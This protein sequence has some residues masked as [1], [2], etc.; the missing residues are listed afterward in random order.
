MKNEWRWKFWEIVATGWHC[1]EYD[2]IIVIKELDFLEAKWRILRIIS[3]FGCC[4]QSLIR[5]IV[6]SVIYDVIMCN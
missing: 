2:V 6:T 1:N 4:H 5:A 3:G